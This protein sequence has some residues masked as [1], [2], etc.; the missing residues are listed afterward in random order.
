MTEIIKIRDFAVHVL[1]LR[2]SIQPILSDP[3]IEDL[4][5]PGRTSPQATIEDLLYQAAPALKQAA[6]R[7]DF[8]RCNLQCRLCG[9]ADGGAVLFLKSIIGGQRKYAV[10]YLFGVVRF[11][12]TYHNVKCGDLGGEN[13]V[14]KV[15]E[16]AVRGEGRQ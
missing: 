7:S 14:Q 2:E 5:L 8:I 16:G 12:V 6:S 13:G 10:G 4:Y 3:T 1:N 9:R 15:G 11:I